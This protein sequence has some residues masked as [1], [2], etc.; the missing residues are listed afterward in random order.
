MHIAGSDLPLHALNHTSGEYRTEWN[1]TGIDPTKQTTRQDLLLTLQ[2]NGYCTFSYLIHGRQQSLS[3]VWKQTHISESWLMM[4]KKVQNYIFQSQISHVRMLNRPTIF[5][6]RAVCWER[7]SSRNS[8]T[9]TTAMPIGAISWKVSYGRA[10][11]TATVPLQSSTKNS[12]DPRD[13]LCFSNIE[14][15]YAIARYFGTIA[16]K[17]TH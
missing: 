12:N 3:L 7:R 5:R 2:V 9:R 4:F 1:T 14:N 13:F 11:L 15:Q 16:R 10:R 6:G 17:C 8:T